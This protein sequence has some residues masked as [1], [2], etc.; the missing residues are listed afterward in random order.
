MWVEGLVNSHILLRVDA[1][2]GGQLISLRQLRDTLLQVLHFGIHSIK[3]LQKAVNT[4]THFK[5][6]IL[7]LLNENPKCH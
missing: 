1:A 6:D 5:R 7:S 2:V 3:G 4:I